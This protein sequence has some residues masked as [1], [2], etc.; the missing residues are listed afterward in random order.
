MPEGTSPGFD[1][2]LA[3]FRG[4]EEWGASAV[5]RRYHSRLIAYLLTRGFRRPDAEDL[6]SETWLRIARSLATFEGSEREFRGWLFSIA[7]ARAVDAHRARARRPEVLDAEPD[8]GPALD[9]PASTVVDG[10]R[11]D[12]IL[13]VLRSLPGDQADVVALRVL[14]G[15]D[16]DEV[17]RLLGKR[18][19]TIRV[20]QSRA[21]SRLAG[22][23]DGRDLRLGVTE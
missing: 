15:L 5:W 8:P 6:A 21:L 1:A 22:L 20:I 12:E 18:P 13:A 9:D 11:L 23:V 10:I 7:R 19:G 4:G 2:E 17:G 16:A 14:A 3:A